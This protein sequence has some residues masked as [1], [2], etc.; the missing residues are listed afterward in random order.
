MVGDCLRVYF[1]FSSSI[2]KAKQNYEIISLLM[3]RIIDTCREIK[4]MK[5][6]AGCIV[7]GKV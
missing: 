6:G 7:L 2:E 4:K 5:E 3:W 1:Y